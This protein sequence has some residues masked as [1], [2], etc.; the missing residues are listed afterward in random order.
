[1]QHYHVPR[2]LRKRIKAFYEYQFASGGFT[3]SSAI[4][5][6]LPMCEMQFLSSINYQ[7]MTHYSLQSLT[8]QPAPFSSELRHDVIDALKADMVHHL[9]AFRHATPDVIDAVSS[10][11]RRHEFR[12]NHLIARVGDTARSIWI[13]G[14]GEVHFLTAGVEED[15][16]TIIDKCGADEDEEEVDDRVMLILRVGSSFGMGHA[17]SVSGGKYRYVV[18]T[19]APSELY[20]LDAEG[21]RVIMNMWP[22]FA[23][24]MLQTSSMSKIVRQ[25][26]SSDPDEIGFPA[27]KV[28]TARKI[29]QAGLG[30]ETARRS[31]GLH[32]VT[33]LVDGE[34]QAGAT[35]ADLKVMMQTMAAQMATLSGQIEDLDQEIHARIDNM[36]ENLERFT[37]E[38]SSGKARLPRLA[39]LHTGTAA[40]DDK[41]E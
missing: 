5:K 8:F 7:P 15:L 2:A 22:D 27:S 26:P 39:D 13:L 24:G 34:R 11:L 29:D 20:E 10:R 25:S 6:E 9:G 21:V 37:G 38:Q 28:G 40:K 4:M 1:V 35:V 19:R 30:M 14:S 31:K 36:N 33:N 32:L 16:S 23:K 18:L 12:S 41:S 17:D 3:N